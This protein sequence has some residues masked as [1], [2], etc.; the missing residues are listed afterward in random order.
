MKLG[1][2]VFF[3]ILFFAACFDFFNFQW[4]IGNL[5]YFIDFPSLLIVL[6]PTIAF[7]IGSYS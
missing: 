6:G 1:I 2:I 4:H 7:A 3:V 5:K